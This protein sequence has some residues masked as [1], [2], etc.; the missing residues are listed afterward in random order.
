MQRKI[1]L[2]Q[3]ICLRIGKTTKAKPHRVNLRSP[4]LRIH[5][6]HNKRLQVNE[7]KYLILTYSWTLTPINNW[8]CSVVTIFPFQCMA[9]STWLTNRFMNPST[10]LTTNWSR[11]LATKFFSLSTW[12]RS[13]SFLVTKPYGVQTQ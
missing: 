11:M 9:P 3:A 12:W 5:Y 2:T 8:T 6:Y 7:F 4:L 13:Q 1:N 10:W